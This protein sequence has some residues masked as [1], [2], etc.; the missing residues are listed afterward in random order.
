ML[1]SHI[2]VGS[3]TESDIQALISACQPATFGRGPEN[4][5]DETYRKAWKMDVGSFSWL[6]NP[7]SGRFV[8]E[9]AQ[10]FCP[11]DQLDRGIRIEA[12]KLNVYGEHIP[13]L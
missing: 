1:S 4:V 13:S 10:K 11:W 9:L 5:L 12:Y 6:F 7:D 3:T 8:A 2:Q